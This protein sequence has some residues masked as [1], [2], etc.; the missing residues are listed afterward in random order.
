MSDEIYNDELYS[1]LNSSGE[2]R[3]E[4]GGKEKY[5]YLTNEEIIELLNALEGMEALR[6][7][8]NMARM[9]RKAA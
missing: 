3:V 9:Q 7:M 2:I 4:I 5:R 6:E 1:L 8:E